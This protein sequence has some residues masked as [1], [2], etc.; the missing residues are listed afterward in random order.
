MSDAARA[1]RISGDSY[2]V[3]VRTLRISSKKFMSLK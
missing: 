1:L 3:P 2:I